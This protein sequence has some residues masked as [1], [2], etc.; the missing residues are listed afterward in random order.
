MES[1]FSLRPFYFVPSLCCK[2]GFWSLEALA[3]Q[4]RVRKKREGRREGERKKEREEERKREKERC[5]E[6]IRERKWN[7]SSRH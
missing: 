7:F 5:R 1:I 4:E 2:I 6:R 3:I